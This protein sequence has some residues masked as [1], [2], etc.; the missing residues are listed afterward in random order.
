MRKWIIFTL[1][2]V[3]I[4][5]A[6][7][8][9]SKGSQIYTK[10]GCY[11]CHGVNAEGS[12]DFP[13]LAGKSK[14]YLKRKLLGYKNGTI[15]SGRANMMRPFAKSLSEKEIDILAE[16][17]KSLGHKKQNEERYYEDFV[18]GDSSGS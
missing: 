3:C 5:A 17:L 13:K 14:Y 1:S 18:I 6:D 4:W 8:N 2:V 12:N 10:H 7:T 11:G 16:Y 15:H 9:N